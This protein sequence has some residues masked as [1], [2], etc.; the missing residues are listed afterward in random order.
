MGF[1]P[2]LSSDLLKSVI[3]LK[4]IIKSVG[5]K[6]YWNIS[7]RKIQNKQTNKTPNKKH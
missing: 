2:I 3:H 6:Q 7:S 1:S 5:S 4:K